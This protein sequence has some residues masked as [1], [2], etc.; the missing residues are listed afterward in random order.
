[1]YAFPALSREEMKRPEEYSRLEKMFHSGT[2]PSK[3]NLQ[4]LF[5]HACQRIPIWTSSSIRQYWW[6]KHNKIID[7]GIDEYEEAPPQFKTQCKVRPAIIQEIKPEYAE[8]IFKN[9][10]EPERVLIPKYLNLKQN[11]YVTV[12]LRRIDEQITKQDY[13]NFK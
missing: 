5:P 4:E 12:H 1:M 7:E 2:A 11:N 8:I 6:V 13:D 3:K 9:Q 10:E